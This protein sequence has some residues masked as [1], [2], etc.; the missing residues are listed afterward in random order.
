M[1]RYFVTGDCHGRFERIWRFIKKFDL[2]AG[3]TIIVCGDMG[4]YWNKDQRD[5][6]YSIREYEANCNGVNLW[7]IDGNHEN[8]DIIKTFDKPTHQC[9]PHITYISRGTSMLVKIGEKYRNLL[10]MGGADSVDKI[11]RTEHIS[12]WADET[13]TEDDIKGIKGYY[14]YVFSHA[15]P[16]GVFTN[17]KAF[18]CTAN[19]IN[20]NNAIHESERVLE[21]LRKNIEYDNWFFGHYHVDTHVFPVDGEMCNYRCVYNDF[22]EL[23]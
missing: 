23:Q 22:I 14:H 5:A 1:G 21:K 16:L 2:G 18:L 11:F 9:S 8:F 4:L 19:N 15:C 10:F 12:W 3:D 7:W 17:N 20:E 6:R 13:I